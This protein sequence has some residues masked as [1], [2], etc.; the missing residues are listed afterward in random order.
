MD[1]WD[2]GNVRRWIIFCFGFEECVM[3]NV[4]HSIHLQ[5][6]NPTRQQD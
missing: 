6:Q 1:G 4:E 3:Y 5:M 2:G